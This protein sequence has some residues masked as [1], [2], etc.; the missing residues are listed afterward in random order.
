[1]RSD[2]TRLKMIYEMCCYALNHRFVKN[3]IQS[4]IYAKKLHLH[5]N[6]FFIS[7]TCQIL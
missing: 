5:Q 4:L 6:V 7:S 1:M 3:A 2:P